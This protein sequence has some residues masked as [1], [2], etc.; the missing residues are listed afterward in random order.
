MA[1]TSWTRPERRRIYLM[2]HAE[3]S[4]FDPTSGPF[5]PFTVPLN[6]EGREQAAAAATLLA[7]VP[8]DRAICSGLTRTR[9][10]GK[11]V[12]AG[13]LLEIETRDAF[14]EIEPGNVTQISLDEAHDVFVKALAGDVDRERSFL[15]GETFGALEDRV[16]DSFNQLLGDDRW[17]QLLIVA[18]G[19]VNRVILAHALGAGLSSFGHLEQ[20][21]ACINIIDVQKGGRHVVRAINFTPYN[22]LKQGIELTTMERLFAQYVELMTGKKPFEP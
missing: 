15:G 1:A 10:T 9:E 17:R 5:D 12:L 11:L 4:Y 2:R 21:A 13:R 20:D 22:P 7:D 19:I 3:V 8:L 18:H 6:E 14:R 16:L